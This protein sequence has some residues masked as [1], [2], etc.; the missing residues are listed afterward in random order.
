MHLIFS[1]RA[2]QRIDIKSINLQ[3]ITILFVRDTSLSIIIK[4]THVKMCKSEYTYKYTLL[5][6]NRIYDIACFRIAYSHF[7]TIELN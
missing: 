1:I 2:G 7:R 3:T 6:L 4:F 5:K